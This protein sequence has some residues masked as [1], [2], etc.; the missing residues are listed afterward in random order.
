MTITIHLSDRTVQA[1]QERVE[2]LKLN[3]GREMTV[4]LLCK[5]L[6]ENGVADWRSE[7]R[8]AMPASHYVARNS[9]DE[10]EAE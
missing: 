7:K 9:G 4:A 1:L 5:Q 6:I 3:G 10:W 8:L 2:F